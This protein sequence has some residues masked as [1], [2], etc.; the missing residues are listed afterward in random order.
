ME[1]TF[2][3]ISFRNFGYTSGGWPKIPENRNNRRNLFH[4]TIPAR[5]QFLRARKSNNMAGASCRT[6]LQTARAGSWLA[7]LQRKA[8]TCFEGRMAARRDPFPSGILPVVMTARVNRSRTRF[9]F[10]RLEELATL[11]NVM[12][13]SSPNSPLVL[14]SEPW[15]NSKASKR[16]KESAIICSPFVYF[17]FSRET[18][19]RLVQP[20]GK[21]RFIRPMEYPKFR[22]GIFGQLESAPELKKKCIKC[23]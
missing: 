4:S 21:Y 3:G 16:G 22:S 23:S 2:S 18:W 6:C 10:I 20:T 12:S 9:Q 8:T 15:N 7:I 1:Q 19:E 13:S 11:N 14:T 17:V 5:A